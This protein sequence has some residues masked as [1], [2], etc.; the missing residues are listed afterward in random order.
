MVGKRAFLCVPT[1]QSN[2]AGEK[3]SKSTNT[4]QAQVLSQVVSRM[5]V[6]ANGGFSTFIR[7]KHTGIQI[8]RQ[9]T[10]EETSAIMTKVNISLNGLNML[11]ALLR[12]QGFNQVFSSTTKM[13]EL[14]ATRT[15]QNTTSQ[16]L[17]FNSSSGK[18]CKGYLI[19]QGALEVAQLDLDLAAENGTLSSLKFLHER[20][21]DGGGVY[22]GGT[23]HLLFSQ[24]KGGNAIK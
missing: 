17:E 8:G 6:D 19:T 12:Y 13:K 20:G 21:D 18:P 16:I 23:F 3:T 11:A 9:F 1:G 4:R 2:R 14:L 5:R 10:P 7:V 15:C 24:D 22:N